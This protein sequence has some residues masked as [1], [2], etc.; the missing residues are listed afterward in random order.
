MGGYGLDK[1]DCYVVNYKFLYSKDGLI[2]VE[3]CENG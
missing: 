1:V 3:Y 2:W